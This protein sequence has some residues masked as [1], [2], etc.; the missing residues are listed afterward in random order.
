VTTLDPAL[1]NVNT[2][3]VLAHDA[4]NM[5]MVSYAYTDASLALIA[6][7]VGMNFYLF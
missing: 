4:S 6:V 5:Q 3:Y 2:L 1:V 7:K